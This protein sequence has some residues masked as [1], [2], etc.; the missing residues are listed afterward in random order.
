[1]T[2]WTSIN[3]DGV[4]PLVKGLSFGANTPPPP[5]PVPVDEA[6]AKWGTRV[7]PFDLDRVEKIL[8]SDGLA[9]GRGQY[10]VVTE[11]QGRRMQIHHEP[12]SCPWIQIE[13]VLPCHDSKAQAD[14]RCNEWNNTRMQPTAFVVERGAT[15]D[16][17]FATRF[18]V[19]H[20]LSD[21]QLHTLLR[22]GIGVTLQAITA[23]EAPAS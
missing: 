3:I 15:D 13:A 18:Y 19:E 17:V 4:E 12:A 7:E 20:G 5:Q 16:I 14:E 1:M 23:F 6:A 22:R 10:I 21:R 9:T 11:V 2:E 8:N